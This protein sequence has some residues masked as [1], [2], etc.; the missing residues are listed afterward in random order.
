MEENKRR[1]K[2][3]VK[4]GRRIKK[5][6]CIFLF[7]LQWPVIYW[8]ITAAVF[9]RLGSGLF[10]LP[11]C[12]A[13]RISAFIYRSLWPPPL[14]WQSRF[15]C[16]LYE[17]M[18]RRRRRRRGRRRADRCTVCPAQVANDVLLAC[19]VRFIFF[20]YFLSREAEL[21]VGV[22]RKR[23][24]WKP[25]RPL[26]WANISR[27][28]LIRTAAGYIALPQIIYLIVSIQFYYYFINAYTIDIGLCSIYHR[29]LSVVWCTAGIQMI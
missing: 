22:A 16:S 19:R 13:G 6:K 3:N 8:R 14:P 7:L 4:K 29:W 21:R 18:R 11:Q 15:D 23:V 28:E 1:K 24:T 27:S 25:G 5:A 9:S 2:K 10:G 26:I 12:P 20:F 17:G